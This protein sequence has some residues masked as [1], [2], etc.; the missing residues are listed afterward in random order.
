MPQVFKITTLEFQ[1]KKD[2]NFGRSRQTKL[3]RP[4]AKASKLQKKNTG[5]I[6]NKKISAKKIAHN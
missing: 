5:I 4:R 2:Y 6:C 1:K 3:G